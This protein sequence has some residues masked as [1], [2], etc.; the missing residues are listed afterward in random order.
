MTSRCMTLLLRSLTS[1]DSKIAPRTLHFTLGNDRGA[2]ANIRT[3]NTA[4]RSRKAT[5]F[6]SSLKRKILAN[7]IVASHIG[8]QEEMAASLT[9]AALSNTLYRREI[10]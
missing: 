4:L 8:G 10:G 9:S 2:P 5:S 3:R 7:T 6:V 1:R